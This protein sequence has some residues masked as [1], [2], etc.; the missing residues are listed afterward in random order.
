MSH[1]QFPAVERPWLQTVSLLSIAYFK[2]V[3]CNLETDILSEETQ[4]TEKLRLDF[5][6]FGHKAYEM[7]LSA[8]HLQVQS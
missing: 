5:H 1:S 7:A 4:C 3:I 6:F 2:R 8:S